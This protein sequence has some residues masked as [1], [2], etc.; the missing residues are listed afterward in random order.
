MKI[1]NFREL[2]IDSLR[3]KALKIAE[4]GLQVIDTEKII[5]ESVVSKDNIIAIN[6]HIYSL[7]D[8]A[9]VFVVGIGKASLAAAKAL[10]EILGDK[11]DGGIVLDIKGGKLNKIESLVGDHPHPSERNVEHTKK[12]ID[13][14]KK[15]KEDDLVI[16]IISGGGSA[17]LCQ[18]DKMICQKEAD[19][20][21]DLF[22]KGA[23]IYEINTIRKHLSLARGGNL[24]KYAYPA[25]SVSLLFSDIPG[26]DLEFIASGPTFKDT[27]VVKD[28]EKVLKKYGFNP[29][30]FYLLETPK[31][32]KY[33]EKV[34]NVLLVSNRKAIEVMVKKAREFNYS[35]NPNPNVCLS[36]ITG[37]A[38][39]VGKQLAQVLKNKP[40]KS[41][42]ILGGET[43][44]KITGKG[45]GG[46]N[47]ELVLSALEDICQNCVIIAIASDGID[48]CDYAGAVGDSITKKKA[49]QLGL[50]IKEY[51]EDNNSCE[52][53]KKTRNYIMTGVTG[54]NVADL[55]IALK[56]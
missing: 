16:F 19:L 2:A 35:T 25:R 33:F 56:D 24:A 34:N 53:F 8:V 47:Q 45:V 48:N 29:V 49:Q 3:E 44:V 51:L 54:S 42:M 5:K 28:A 37:E 30:N 15:L 6:E 55:I 11:I 18:P 23:T 38:E 4:A 46:R 1:I 26:D 14:L 36:C 10:E 22:E 31:D 21:K 39:I 17:L 20:A 13:F 41:A 9:N 12:L 32:A 7:E 27:T 40:N 43:I 50:S 52:F